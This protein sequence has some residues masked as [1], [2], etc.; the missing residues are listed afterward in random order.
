MNVEPLG[1]ATSSHLER[2]TRSFET[3]TEAYFEECSIIDQRWLSSGGQL[4]A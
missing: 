4:Q 3:P 1:R 2:R